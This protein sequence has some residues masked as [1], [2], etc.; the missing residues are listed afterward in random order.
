M[1]SAFFNGYPIVYSDTSTYLASGFEIE[2]PVDRPITYGLFLG[3]AS[4]NGLSLWLV[5]FFQALIL[6]YL[7]FQLF[8]LIFGEKKYLTFGIITIGF[9]SVLTGVSWSAGQLL[10][11]IF[12]SIA[13]LCMILIL[14]GSLS[15]KESILMYSLFFLSIAMHM[16]HLILFSL[17]LA[18]IF[19]LRNYILP[20][21]VYPWRNKQIVI[22][23][24]LT[25]ATIISMGAAMSKSRHIF[26]MGS[27]VD[28]GI[29]KEY[30]DEKCGST[31]YKLCTYKDSM[32]TTFNDFVWNENSPLP[33]MG[34]WKLVKTEF[35]DIITGVLTQ[36]R[37]IGMM[38]KQS[39]IFTFRQL[40]HFGIGDGN[41]SFLQGT[42]LYERL[43]KYFNHEIPWYSASKQN[44]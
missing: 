13:V 20:G 23:F 19:V 9:L 15:K 14:F 29:I 35:N 8:K 37:Y 7:I 28:K 24:V 33:K 43:S 31:N 3:A 32:P 27:M 41:G 21:H 22:M 1:V 11:D 36:P 4:L 40:I 25:W 10:P 5:I 12:T 17:M 44:H 26:F 2:T 6:S 34:G 30:L 39:I 18:I 38:I 16:S 42:R